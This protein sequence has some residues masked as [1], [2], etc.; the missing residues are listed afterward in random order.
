MV[1]IILKAACRIPKHVKLKSNDPPR[2]SKT[3]VIFL[4][5]GMSELILI[6]YP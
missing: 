5:S 6:H 2:G 4:E 1:F 3:Q